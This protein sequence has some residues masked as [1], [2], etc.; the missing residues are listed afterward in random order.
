M[1]DWWEDL[2]GL[3]KTDPGDAEGDLDKDGVKNLDEFEGGSDPT[4]PQD[5]PADDDDDTTD[6]NIGWILGI[7]IALVILSLIIFL[8]IFFVARSAGGKEEDWEE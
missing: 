7:I 8:V 2:Y 4:D 3:N 1:P 5:L 6:S